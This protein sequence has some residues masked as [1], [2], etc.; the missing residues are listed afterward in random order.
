MQLR[1]LRQELRVSQQSV[2]AEGTNNNLWT[3]WKSYLFF[4]LYF[5]FAGM[6]ASVETIRLFAQFG[7]ISCV[8]V[9]SIRN[10]ISGVKL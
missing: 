1:V 4:S 2:F 10:Y 3:I 7:G 6:P 9:N 8:N 5:G